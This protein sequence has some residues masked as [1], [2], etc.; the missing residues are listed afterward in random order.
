MREAEL[1]AWQ[2][3]L[4]EPSPSEASTACLRFGVAKVA[5]GNRQEGLLLMGVVAVGLGTAAYAFFDS[6]QLMTH[7]QNLVQFVQNLLG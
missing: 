2:K 7:V 1:I 4:P 6:V 5:S 3:S